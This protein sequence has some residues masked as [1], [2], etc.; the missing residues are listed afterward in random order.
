MKLGT[1]TPS[2]TLKFNR[3]LRGA[4]YWPGTDLEEATR[5]QTREQRTV[6]SWSL[7]ASGGDRQ[8]TRKQISEQDGFGWSKGNETKRQNEMTVHVSGGADVKERP[9]G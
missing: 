2:C 9:D 5:P 8:Q 3:Y 6:P 7:H 4:F 1:G